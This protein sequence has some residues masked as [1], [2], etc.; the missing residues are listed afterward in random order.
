MNVVVEQRSQTTATEMNFN[1]EE[2]QRS[3]LIVNFTGLLDVNVWN[4][5]A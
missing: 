4:I 5:H 1:L 3:C 2:T